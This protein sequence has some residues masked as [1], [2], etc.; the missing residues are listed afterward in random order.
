MAQKG[1]S[2]PDETDE[3]ENKGACESE[4]ELEE[5]RHGVDGELGGQMRGEAAGEGPPRRI[6]YLRMRVQS[7]PV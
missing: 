1:A 6:G 5:W 7:S 3:K 2:A 4:G